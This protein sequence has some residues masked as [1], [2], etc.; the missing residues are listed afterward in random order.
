MRH[1]SISLTFLAVS[2]ALP[3]TGTTSQR[4]HYDEPYAVF[5][6][7][8]PPRVE[9]RP[10]HITLTKI[11]DE[12]VTRADELVKPGKVKVSADSLGRYASIATRVTLEVDAKPCTRYFLAGRRENALSKEF[13]LYVHKTEPILEC[14]SQFNK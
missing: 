9:L 3:A 12:H 1:L 7:K 11:G 13:E 14:Q 2:V 10:A 4:A 6:T 8:E 5:T